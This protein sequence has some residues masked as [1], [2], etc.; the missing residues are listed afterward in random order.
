MGNPQNVDDIELTGSKAKTI[1]THNAVSV[2]G[3]NGSSS[4]TGTWIDCDGFRELAVTF[5]NDAATSSLGDVRWSNDGS[6]YQAVDSA[7]IPSN[8]NQRKAASIP[9]KA[10]YAILNLTNGDVAAHTMSAWLYL[11]V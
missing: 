7:V 8:T 6:T 2:T 5:L 10:R 4:G 1:Q 3:S 9:V 11:K